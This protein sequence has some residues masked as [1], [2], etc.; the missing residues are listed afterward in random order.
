MTGARILAEGSRLARAARLIAHVGLGMLIA[1]VVIP[2]T[3]RRSK[4]RPSSLARRLTRR[5]MQ[6]LCRLLGLRVEIE[7]TV[8]PGPVLFVANHISWLDIPALRAAVD[9]DFVSKH[10]VLDWPA[11][12]R[13]ASRVGTIFLKRGAPKAAFVAADRM[14][15]ALTQGRS[16]IV[17]P[18]GTTTDGRTVRHFHARLYQA[19]IRTRTRV[20]PVAIAY[21]HAAGT[22]PLAPFIGDKDLIGH[23]WGLLGQKEMGVKLHFCPPIVALS[24]ARRRTLADHTRERIV[25]ALDRAGSADR[26]AA[27]R[28]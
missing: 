10:E 12:G 6:D 25:Q 15:W 28:G 7:G 4:D 27:V 17:F 21:P 14:T 5:W 18:E 2:F 13:M 1:H 3:I 19:A 22:N 24:T 23:L 9:A 26:P 20:Q 11:I 16:L 8:C